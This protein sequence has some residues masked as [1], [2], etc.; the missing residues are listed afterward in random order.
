[1]PSTEL[2]LEEMGA[3]KIS[4]NLLKMKVNNFSC[5]NLTIC[6]VYEKD[7]GAARKCAAA[8]DGGSGEG[9]R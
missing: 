9:S 4:P 5:H 2:S 3:A 6:L 1:M 8:E 7:C